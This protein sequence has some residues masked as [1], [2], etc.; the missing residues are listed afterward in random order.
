[1]TPLIELSIPAK[2]KNG[3]A[4]LAVMEQH[5][6]TRRFFVG[7]RYTIADIALYAYTHV[8]DEGGFEL[9]RFPA[10]QDWLARVRAEPRHVPITAGEAGR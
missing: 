1:M 9:G 5:L 3:E 7:G 8:A 10:V 6:A 4:A 2:R